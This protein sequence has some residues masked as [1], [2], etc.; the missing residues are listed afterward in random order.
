[1]RLILMENIIKPKRLNFAEEMGLL[2]KTITKPLDVKSIKPRLVKLIKI[3]IDP[4][5]VAAITSR[6]EVAIKTKP[7]Q[8]KNVVNDETLVREFRPDYIISCFQITFEA[9]KE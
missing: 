2:F 3:K 5:D 1:M 9:D 6:I 7:A 8:D 4:Y